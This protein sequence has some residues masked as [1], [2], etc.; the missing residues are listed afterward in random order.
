MPEL[1]EVETIRRQLEPD[2]NGRV[3]EVAEVL[4][5]YFTKPE[6]AGSFERAVNGR[7]IIDVGRRG[8]YL[9]FEFDDKTTMV[10]HLRMTG[11]I[12]LLAP[13]GS[14]NPGDA[15]I[16][17]A[18]Q[19][20]RHLK[21]RFTLDDGGELRFTDPRRF[22]RGFVANPED[23]NSYFESRL[24]VEPL[25]E[26][27]TVDALA[28]MTAGRTGPLKSFLLDQ[29]GV[30]GV[31]NIY[32]DEALFRAGLHP[33]SPG[34][35]MKPE[36]HVALRDGVVEALER[37]LD[38]GG[39]SI[40]DYRDARGEQG[41]MQNEFLVHR[42]EGEECVNCGSEIQRIVVG[43]RSTYFCPSCQK[44]LRRRPKRRRVEG[45][46]RAGRHH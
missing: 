26:D 28:S 14:E 31:G 25:S 32:A 44:R 20:E 9:L 5:D 30:V 3:V 19:G 36:N 18:G 27:F 7:E 35:S 6:P 33:L 24:G 2:L 16:H 45:G 41:G 42:R 21:A 23:L 11:S 40:D 39:A 8:K 13:D 4:D 17:E 12:V 37:G 43:G 15:R 34:A 29:K 46:V 1:P 10:I 22:G 38:L